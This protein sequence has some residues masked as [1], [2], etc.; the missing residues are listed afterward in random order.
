METFQEVVLPLI[1]KN[2]L[3]ASISATLLIALFISF[4]N[5]GFVCKYNGQNQCTPESSFLKFDEDTLCQGSVYN[6]LAYNTS[7]QIKVECPWSLWSTFTIFIGTVSG[8]LFGVSFVLNKLQEDFVRK[9]IRFQLGCASLII[10]LVSLISK[11]NT[12]SSGSANCFAFENALINLGAND[13]SYKC[14]TSI[15]QFEIILLAACFIGITYF[16]YLEYKGH[17]IQGDENKDE[18]APYTAAASENDY[19][20]R[21][22][23]NN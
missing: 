18:D 20:I 9:D 14:S 3:I 17:A 19:Q 10:I 12:V 4:Y 8:I 11:I 6:I 5:A 2:R 23:E 22:F 1:K 13:F 7:T 16:V 21:F 15:F